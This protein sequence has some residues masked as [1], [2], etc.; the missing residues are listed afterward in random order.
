MLQRKFV[1][2]PA[3]RH[4]PA[5]GGGGGRCRVGHGKCPIFPWRWASPLYP[6]RLSLRA[7][8]LWCKVAGGR[9]SSL[10]LLLENS[11]QCAV[12]SEAAS[13]SA[14][15]RGAGNGRC[16]VGGHLAVP[17]VS[18]SHHLGPNVACAP[19]CLLC[20]GCN[21]NPA[22]TASVGR[23]YRTASAPRLSSNPPPL[24]IPFSQLL[25]SP[26]SD[27]RRVCAEQSPLLS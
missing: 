27:L 8:R 7:P 9:W 17:R 24:L 3:S 2:S 20:K 26:C 13:E 19:H 6:G 14:F 1:F 5:G 12:L 15:C 16:S 10:H 21:P 18:A 22:A 4:L 23:K 25:M 11:C